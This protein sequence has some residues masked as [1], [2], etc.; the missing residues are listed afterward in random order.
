MRVLRS[1]LLLPIEFPSGASPGSI[2]TLQSTENVV[3]YV[4]LIT[5]AGARHQN[6]PRPTLTNRG[7]VAG[8]YPVYFLVFTRKA[9]GRTGILLEPFVVQDTI[10]PQTLIF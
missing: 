3:P 4:L 7:D 6:Q 9:R 1:W 10:S 5:S 8:L 2:T